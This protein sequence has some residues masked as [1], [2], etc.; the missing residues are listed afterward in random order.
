MVFYCDLGLQ[1]LLKQ[2]GSELLNLPAL[3]SSVAREPCLEI[4]LAVSLLRKFL[5]VRIL[6]CG[7]TA[8]CKDVLKSNVCSL[9]C[10]KG[11]IHVDYFA[12]FCTF[13]NTLQAVESSCMM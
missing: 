13:D 2:L 1:A 11:Q 3:C 10:Q 4:V 9:T 12:S 5:C 6:F 7:S 8:D